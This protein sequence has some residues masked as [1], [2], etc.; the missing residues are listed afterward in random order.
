MRRIDAFERARRAV[1]ADQWTE[2]R[3]EEV[4]A[5]PR[6]CFRSLLDFVGLA[7]TPAFEAGFVRYRFR[8]TRSFRGDLSPANLAR[9][10]RVLAGH[11]GTYGYELTEPAVTPRP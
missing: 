11:L 7:W 8:P 5:D 1:P 6:A 9:L 3:F 4:V 2:V 10:E